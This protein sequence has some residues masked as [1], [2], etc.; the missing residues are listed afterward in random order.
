MPY[1]PGGGFDREARWIAAH[2]PSLLPKKVTM[3]VE[4]NP[5]AGG[6][7]GITKIYKSK[8]DGYT[9]GTLGFPALL[10]TQ[11][12]EAAE[13]DPMKFVYLGDR[14]P[15]PFCLAVTA[16]SP[17]NSLEDLQKADKELRIGVVGV[18][19]T[20]WFVSKVAIAELKIPAVFIGG[21]SGASGVTTATLR[22]EL[23]IHIRVVSSL[24]PFFESGDFK[25]IFMINT[26]RN[27]AIPDTPTTMELGYERISKLYSRRPIIAPP[28]THKE[29]TDI[30]E[31]A[32]QTIWQDKEYIKW[33]ET[34]NEIVKPISGKEMMNEI[35]NTQETIEKYREILK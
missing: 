13:Y 14:G 27:E 26:E 32:L 7:T 33:A 5:G 22:G 18:G 8:P 20:D 34:N 16:D 29:I 30:L 2:L 25:P 21:Y 11:L 10:V 35:I 31:N 15:N 9:L 19:G 6:R 3:I 24:T 17:Y 28:G 23:D 4:N 1:S 12:L